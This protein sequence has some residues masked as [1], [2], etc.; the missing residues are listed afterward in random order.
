MTTVVYC[1]K[2]GLLVADR[3]ISGPKSSATM[4][5]IRRLK[6]GGWF[7][8]TGD[9]DDIER[10]YAWLQAGKPEPRP[11][12][13]SMEALIVYPHALYSLDDPCT[14]IKIR[15]RLMVLGTGSEFA[16]GALDAGADPVQAV[17]IAIKRDKNSGG[18][19]QV[20]RVTSKE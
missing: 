7:V 12:F 4:D 1:P 15:N 13:S 10:A 18:K 20:V 17:R 2:A 5:K 14:L 11:K 3:L 9:C 6:D 16:L 19:P 8:G